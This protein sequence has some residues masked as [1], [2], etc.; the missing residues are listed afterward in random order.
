[1]YFKELIFISFLTNQD[2][3]K[4]NSGPFIK[5]P[6]DIIMENINRHPYLIQMYCYIAVNRSLT[7]IMD[8]RLRSFLNF[9]N[10][11]GNKNSDKYTDRVKSHLQYL[12]GSGYIVVDKYTNLKDLDINQQLLLFVDEDKFNPQF[13][14]QL[15]VAEYNAISMYYKFRNWEQ[16]K[17]IRE[18]DVAFNRLLQILCY[19]RFRITK[20]SVDQTRYYD[21]EKVPEVFYR[22]IKDIGAEIATT[23]KTVSTA[24]G[25]LKNKLKILYYEPLPRYEDNYGNWHTETTIFANYYEPD[26]K[27]Y[28]FGWE[29]EIEWGKKK[30]GIELEHEKKQK[31]KN[32]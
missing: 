1:M 8:T 7:W 11:G 18:R 27:N 25:V 10:I 2:Y 15:F 24:I 9:L 32:K 30:L 14:T 19:I 5:I 16:S 20:R 22:H 23:D 13:Y 28:N 31:S 12:V 29:K 26:E 17:K 4:I 3:K 6:K 21:K